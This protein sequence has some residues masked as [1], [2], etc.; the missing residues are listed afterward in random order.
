[1]STPGPSAAPIPL[2][3]V[4]EPP[5]PPA[6]DVIG[7]SAG[8]GRRPAPAPG[9]VDWATLGVEP[10]WKEQETGDCAAVLS[11]DRGPATGLEPYK[12]YAEGAR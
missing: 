1:M 9:A 7:T 11:S 6:P 5:A 8:Q 3:I 12:R 10:R 2:H 4:G